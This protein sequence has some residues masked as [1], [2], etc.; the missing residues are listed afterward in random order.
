MKVNL[1]QAEAI[2]RRGG[3][4]GLPTETVYGLAGD[5][6]NSDAVVS[7][8]ET[9]GRPAFNPLICHLHSAE[10]VR[11]F[12]RT[13]P[14]F[15]SLS[16]LWPGPLTILLPHNGSIP[17][18]VTSGSDLC[19]FRV[20]SH[21]L[22]LELLRRLDRPVAAPSANRSGRTSPVT[23]GM[24]E[25]QFPNLAVLD[26]GTCSVG[27]ESTIVLCREDGV[28]ILRPGRFA[29]EDFEALGLAVHA[30]SGGVHAPGMLLRHYAPSVPLVLLSPLDMP[31][32]GETESE[33]TGRTAYLGFGGKSPDFAADEIW[34]LSP[35]GNLH[36][37]ARQLFFYFDRI[38]KSGVDT[39]VT[40]LIPEQ[41]IGIAVN[42]RLRRAAD[43]A[44]R[45]NAGR[46]LARK[47]KDHV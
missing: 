20:P 5:A 35:S 26:G 14:S 19:A 44:G 22:A 23:A 34:D 28:E 21:P 2:L 16:T 32:P 37:A 41:G 24:V 15:E 40:E 29:S 46:I 31:E 27:L 25:D 45:R 36:E 17:S 3:L 13:P 39:I 4:I 47:K 10:A 1:D 43:F 6:L 33:V 12:A 30:R 8:F 38:A 7:I 42:D 18:I 11:R 9:K